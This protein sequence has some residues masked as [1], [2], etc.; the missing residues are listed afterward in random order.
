LKYLFGNTGDTMTVF[1]DQCKTAVL[2]LFSIIFLTP[3]HVGAVDLTDASE[4]VV[5]LYVTHQSWNMKQPW[6][7]SGVQV[8]TCS[9][10]Y[11]TEGI[12]TNAHCV[13][14]ATYIQMEVSG[15]PDKIDVEVS[16]INHQVDLAMVKPKDSNFRPNIEPIKLGRLPNVREKI[17]TIGYP[18]GGRQVSYTEGVV[19]RI[20]IMNYSHSNIAS[21]MV[22]TDAAIN[23]GNSGGPVF[24][25][26]SGGCLGVATQKLQGGE[27]IGYFVPT[28]VIKQF[29]NDLV[30][31][32]IEGIPALGITIQPLENPAIRQALDL[33]DE[34]TGVRVVK[35]SSAGS[36]AGKLKGDD[37]I[38][39]IDGH[40]IFN[41]GRVLFRDNSKIDMR[42]YIT[43]RQVGD[44]LDLQ[45]S[46]KGK[47]RRV[48]LD[49]KPYPIF[50]IPRMPQYDKKPR[51]YEIGGIVFQAVEPRYLV[52]W[53]RKWPAKIP[54]DIRGHY[55]EFLGEHDYKE[56]VIVSG[57]FRASANKGYSGF[58]ENTRVISINDSPIKQLSDVPKAFASAGGKF[59]QI[60]LENGARMVLDKARVDEEEAAIR[61]R[62][63]IN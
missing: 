11:F 47:I 63:N 30:D 33:S 37:V 38:L 57:I 53:G 41:D 21:L 9:A 61:Q 50:L 13:S 15:Y 32:R 42:Y 51:Y 39:E 8:S 36:T 17:V 1:R 34:Q 55:S 19:S 60:E 31:G 12:L 28:P 62:Y 4:A 7:K 40:Q 48:M 20:D 22:Q 25:D 44:N 29:L 56:L 27:A 58:V 3:G 23:P 5:K 14:D 2:C 10:F 52:S 49:L 59:Y 24:S 16:A 46:R 45:I 18:A 6:T 43:T 54:N 35:I 26:K